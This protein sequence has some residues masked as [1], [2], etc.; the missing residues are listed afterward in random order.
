MK[1]IEEDTSVFIISTCFKLQIYPKLLKEWK[2]FDCVISNPETSQGFG[3]PQVTVGQETI[4]TMVPIEGTSGLPIS[5]DAEIIPKDPSDQIVLQIEDIPP[6]DVFYSPKHRAVVKR[7]RK[8][9]RLDQS[10]L[11]PDQTEMGNVVWK[12]EFNPSDDLTKLSQYSGAYSKA[13]MDK[14]SEVSN[15]LKE[16]DQIIVSL[17]SQVSE[18]Q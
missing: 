18:A 11:L 16:K 6:L 13:T 3:T 8:R 15:L 2:L 1:N 10:S 17:Q 4:T 9:R 14:A 12:E 7:K 5:K